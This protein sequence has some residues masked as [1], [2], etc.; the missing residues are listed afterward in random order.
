[1]TET[2]DTSLAAQI[3]EANSGGVVM[4]IPA[5]RIRP[6]PLN[7]YEMSDLEELATSIETVGQLEPIKVKP[8]PEDERD[9]MIVD[10]E[11]RF[12]AMT[13]VLDRDAVRALIVTPVDE[14]TEELMLIEA[15]RTQ[16]K[17][18]AA[19]LSKQAERYTELLS[20]LK[21]SGVQIPGRLRDR[22]AEALQVSSAKLGRLHA[23]RERLSPRMLERFD[24][25]QINESMAYSLS[26]YS[27]GQQA[28]LWEHGAR[29]PDDVET[30]ARRCGF[31]TAYR[32]ASEKQPAPEPEPVTRSNTEA[33]TSWDAEAYLK[34]RHEEDEE[35]FDLLCLQAQRYLPTLETVRTR[36]E[37][38]AKLKERFSPSGGSFGKTYF[39]C[40]GNGLTFTY[41]GFQ[42]TRSW[43]EVYDL[44]CIIALTNNAGKTEETKVDTP[45]GMEWHET[46]EDDP[47]E[48]GTVIFWGTAGLRCPPAGAAKTYA[49]MWPDEY[50]WWAA[51]EG[52]E[53][54][55]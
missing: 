5:E 17:L 51:V 23:I 49:E 1:M 25:G 40:R 9:Y 22:V 16:R 36:Q 24:E 33:D 48:D 2:K 10:G 21:D 7:F 27:H 53:A 42:A 30:I 12:R 35:F 44:L 46:W 28:A 43:T 38:I 11:R 34:Q 3:R 18:S 4:L 54:R 32:D 45:A 26:R 31:S 8:D 14:I 52:P 15:N 29:K 20:R 50:R 55:A 39:D 47:P 37:G 13:E 6:N 19:D 41:P